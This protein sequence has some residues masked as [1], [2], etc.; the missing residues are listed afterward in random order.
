MKTRLLLLLLTILSF[1]S[2]A[3]AQTTV[4]LTVQDT[5]SA[6]WNGAWSVSLRLPPGQPITGF[7]LV[8]GGGSTANQSGTLSS[9]LA[10]M[11]LPANACVA[12]AGTQW[13]FTVCFSVT[14]GNCYNQLVVVGV[15]SPQAITLNPPPP[16]VVSGGGSGGGITNPITTGVT[17]GTGGSVSATGTGT[18]TATAVAGYQGKVFNATD[19]AY[20]LLATNSAAANNTA[21]T[22][23]A[24]AVNAYAGGSSIQDR[25]VVYIP[26]G[27][28]GAN[29]TYAYS[30][31]LV[32]T[33]PVVLLCG[34]GAMLNYTGSA[35]AADFGPTGLTFA[36]TNATNQ[37]LNSQYT[38][39]GCGWTGG[40]SM[41][42][43]L[44]FNPVV[45]SPT[46]LN[47]T[48]YDFGNNTSTVY[49]IYISV[50]ISNVY[51]G[52]NNEIINDDGVARNWFRV[53]AT[54]GFSDQAHIHDNF[55][56][57]YQL[58]AGNVTYTMPTG[59]LVWVDGQ[60]SEVYDNNFNFCAPCIRIG[61]GPSVGVNG[62]RI[63][64]N[65]FESVSGGP[66]VATGV[67]QYGDPGSAIFP[68]SLFIIGNFFLSNSASATFAE[69]ASVTTG[70]TN[71]MFANNRITGTFVVPLFQQNNI[72]GQ[73]GNSFWDDIC[74]G[75][76]CTPFQIEGVG[77]SI[78]P[79]GQPGYGLF[80]NDGT[81]ALPIIARTSTAATQPTGFRFSGTGDQYS[82]FVMNNG[83]GS[84]YFG[85]APQNA[86]ST[87]GGLYSYIPNDPGAGG[88]TFPNCGFWMRHYL[89][90]T[91]AEDAILSME[92]GRDITFYTTA[93]NTQTKKFS[94]LNNGGL[95]LG[96]AGVHGTLWV[97]QTAPTIAAGGCGGA[98]A[99]ILDS[100]GT[101]AFAV[102]VGTAPGTTCT[103]TMPTAAHRWVC[104]G[105]DITTNSTSVSQVKQT[106][107]STTTS[108]VLTN[109][110]DVSVATAFVA[111]DV[112]QVICAAD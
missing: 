56:F 19:P 38:I 29:A 54:S 46:I 41:T 112:L 30:G 37:Q 111:S 20:G 17:V 96:G 67:L 72:T 9:G 33:R 106:S 35:H 76:S 85:V 15:G 1:A 95:T 107:A 100:N 83:A 4:N 31:G 110:S 75:V 64:N 87:Y 13:Y 62:T 14:T 66:N 57:N 97:S 98:A 93:S 78:N 99:S 49:G 102:G 73:T 53:D 27:S 103:I 90:S 104:Q 45:L 101:A 34:E 50:N 7:S 16:T 25:P 82:E 88:C 65:Y 47:N 109:Y 28:A 58:S 59:I 2:L 21:L 44:F 60:G 43:G 108:L 39:D 36:P 23:L 51:V 24:T 89:N 71:A 79:W 86:A 40:G 11:S 81:A 94:I 52:P 10:T 42:Q 74:G 92:N 3:E 18:I 5:S 8:C 61:P 48:F 12:P 22:A 105:T 55:S 70:L 69:P 77:A 80:L 84:G 32:F 68:D 91:L 6:F 63:T 26:G